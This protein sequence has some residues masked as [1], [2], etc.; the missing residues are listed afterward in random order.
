[1]HRRTL[2]GL[3][4][5]LG[6]APPMRAAAVA[7]PAPPPPAQPRGSALLAPW[8]GPHGGLPPFGQFAPAD[9]APALQQAIT[10]YRAEVAAIARN[11]HAPTFSNTVAAL[12][13]AGR[14]YGRVLSM[15]YVYASTMSDAPMQQIE[16]DTAPLLAAMDDEITHDAALFKRLQAV[17]AQRASAGLTPE[18]QRLAWV[19]QRRHARQGAAL[20]APTKTRVEAINQRLA[21]LYTQFGQHQ[22]ADEEQGRLVLQDAADLAGLPDSL[23]ADAAAAAAQAGLPGRWLIANTRSAM[24]PFITFARQRALREQGWR[25]WTG[26]GDNGG[27]ND[28]NAVIGEILQLRAERAR[29]FGHASHA[30]WVLEDNMAKTPEAALALMMRVW[31]AATERVRTEVADMQAL[32]N[33]ENAAENAAE[34]GAGTRAGA[35]HGAAAAPSIAPWDYRY[36]AEKVRKAQ[37]DIDEDE[38]KPYLQLDKMREAMFWA[39]GQVFGLAFNRLDGVPVCHPSVTVYRVQRGGQRVG[40]WY[41]DPFARPGKNSGAWMNAYRTQE[42]FRGAVTPIVSNNANFTPGQPGQPVLISWDDAV[43]MFHEFGHALHGLL[44]KVH[45]PSLAGPSVLRDFGEF[46]SQLYEHWLPTR[47]VLGRFAL[48]H[49]TGQPMPA[50]LVDKILHARR[51]NQGFFTV[52]Y[53]AS[54]IYDMQIHL[55]SA[56]LP[57]DQ[58]IDAGQFER[59]TMQTIGCPAEVV[60]RHRPTH[61]GHVFGGEGYSAGYYNYL[62]ADTLTADAAE[63]FAEAG[64]FY[65]K[66]LA[67]RLETTLLRVGNSVPPDEA[68]RHF[69]GRDADVQALMRLRGFAPAAGG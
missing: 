46:P 12:E 55:A 62:W 50:A 15:Y 9:L 36:Y 11:P 17:A 56:Q 44:S 24:E 6:L 20:A 38:I 52:E 60:M 48:H 23:R 13:D 40:L 33:I 10:L 28:N 61:F 5:G 3:L 26:R 37:Y 35:A 31:R 29:L 51:F 66:A 42:N 18:Q 68:F 59:L 69:R 41:F 19:Y 27:A 30:H 25:L 65:N 47:E 49:Q 2:V 53:L 8:A 43:T 34:N 14:A 21:T 39:A 16:R 1:M 63:A 4:A 57:A 58:R 7:P 45:Y 67:R 32:A 64:G 54:A 22:L